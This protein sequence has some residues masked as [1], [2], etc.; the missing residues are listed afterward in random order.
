MRLQQSSAPTGTFRTYQIQ[1]HFFVDGSL[2]ET[3]RNA[4]VI[5]IDGTLIRKVVVMVEIRRCVVGLHQ[6]E[7]LKSE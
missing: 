4:K 6:I 5:G 2:D 3:V 1:C 7:G